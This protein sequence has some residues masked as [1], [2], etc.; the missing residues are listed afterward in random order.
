MLKTI[1]LSLL[2]A[3]PSLLFA[4]T[5]AAAPCTSGSIAS[6]AALGSTG[7]TIGLFS[8]SDFQAL[9]PATGAVASSAIVVAP[10]MMGSSVVGVTF[11]VSP[12]ASGGLYYDD[13]ISYRVGSASASLTGATVDFT[14]SGQTGDAAVSV[15]TQL[16]LGGTFLGADGVSNCST[17]S[18]LDLAVVNVG[19]GPDP[20][21]SLPFG[22]IG[23]V[24]VVTD[25]AYDSGSGFVP[26]SGSTL[27]SA[28]N[29]FDVVAAPAAV[30]EPDLG[31]LMA[32][33]V[34][35]LVVFRRG[36]RARSAIE[37]A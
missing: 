35:G 7:C 21:Y 34:V 31:P 37:S 30:P 6:Y 27:T 29:L 28:I 33:G 19:F 24:G 8:F 3:I 17:A 2:V 18:T 11:T 10:V 20:A 13:L 22:A 23:S 15:N 25:A 36:R 9:P 32:A 4:S 12:T 5:A 1:L 16:C 26:D 14:G